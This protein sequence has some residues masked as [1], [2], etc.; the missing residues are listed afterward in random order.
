MEIIRSFKENWSQ[1]MFVKSY[2]KL[3]EEIPS[4]LPNY[5]QILWGLLVETFSLF[6]NSGQ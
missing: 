3:K 2:R 6:N 4:K 1:L 5:L